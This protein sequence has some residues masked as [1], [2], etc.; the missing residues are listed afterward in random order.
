VLFAYSLGK[1]QRLLAGLER[2]L[3]PIL[4]HGAVRA[5]LPAY[6]AAGVDLPDVEPATP[7]AV[8]AAA[9]RALVIAPP[10]TDGSAWLESCGEIST[11]FASGWM[12]IRGTRRRRGVDRGFALSDHAD[13]PSLVGAIRATGAQRVLVTHGATAPLVRWL[14][15]NGWQA[16][17]LPTRFVGETEENPSQGHEAS[18]PVPTE[19]HPESQR[20][21]PHA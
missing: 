8:R 20:L 17:A 10:A 12:L 16:D 15:E 2:S 11:G 1:A 9:G 4:A 6:A 18:P 14:N 3:G 5:F 13:W 19:T 7:A 21:N